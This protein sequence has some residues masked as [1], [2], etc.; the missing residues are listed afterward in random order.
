MEESN[1]RKDEELRIKDEELLKMKDEKDK[2]KQRADQ[3]EQRKEEEIKLLKAEIDQMKNIEKLKPKQE[4]QKK[5]S[6]PTQDYPI[7]IINND[8]QNIVLSDVDGVMKKISKKN[9]KLTTVS[10]TQILE[11][12]IWQM[13][14]EFNNSQNCAAIGIVRD[15]YNIPTDTH[16]CH[17]PHRNHMVSYGMSGF[18][19]GDGAVKYKGNGTSGNIA[20]KDNQIIKAE[21]DSE[22]GTLIFSVDGVQQPVYVRGI[23]EKVRFFVYMFGSQA[24]CTIRSL[25]KLIAPTTKHVANEIAVQW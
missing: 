8:P 12:G 1:K 7:S 9:I 4:T 16:P 25:K 24:Y 17:D 13:E 6:S 20:Y 23:N 10:L 14:A 2:E 3:A 19:I 22:K 15:T 11:N 21:F 5:Q 18:G